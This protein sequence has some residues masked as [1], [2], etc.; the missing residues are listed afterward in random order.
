[1]HGGRACMAGVCMAG[2]MRAIERRPLEPVV[3]ILLE[4]ILVS[5]ISSSKTN[6]MKPMTKTIKNVLPLLSLTL[7]YLKA[8]WHSEF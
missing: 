4:C 3:R 6:Y 5:N 7:V 2:G 1:M 8:V